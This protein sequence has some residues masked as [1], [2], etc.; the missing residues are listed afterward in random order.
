[1]PEHLEFIKVVGSSHPTYSISIEK[2]LYI[3]VS[4]KEHGRIESERERTN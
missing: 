3:T 2:Q 4:R 1:M